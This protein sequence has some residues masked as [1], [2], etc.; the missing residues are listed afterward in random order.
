MRNVRFPPEGSAS[1][2]AR[3][4]IKE[5][6]PSMSSLPLIARSGGPLAGIVR[7]PGDRALTLQALALGA[8]AVGRTSLRGAF[9]GDEAQRLAA[10]LRALGAGV[11]DHGDGHWTVDGI[12]V[13]GLLEP[14]DVLDLGGGQEALYLLLGLVATHSLTAIFTGDAALNRRPVARLTMSLERIGAQFIGRRGDLPPLAAV[15]A[16]APMPMEHRLPATGASI[17]AA[18]LL[19][20]L[21]T[22]GITSVVESGPAS[23]AMERLLR[24]FGARVEVE[25]EAGGIRRTRLEGQPELTPAA[26]DLPADPSAA[27]LP[28]V[29]ALAAG[30]SSVTLAGVG[31]DPART[32]LF[33][34]LRDMGADIDVVNARTLGEAPVGDL[35]VRSSRLKGLVVPPERMAGLVHDYPLLAVAAARAE[36]TT[37]LSGLGDGR[38]H[39][40]LADGLAACGVEVL[41]EDD[42]LTI[43]GAGGPVPGGA[44]LAADLAPDLAAALLVLGLGAQAPVEVADGRAI[45]GHFPGFAALM[46]GLGAILTSETV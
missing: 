7:V 1:A 31:L 12:G 37:V 24:L 16:T 21:N 32:G 23:D 17:K 19:A 41:V 3:P 43:R 35:H 46:G 20:G 8:M 5:T 2:P 44:R 10:A 33:A 18:I 9:D 34:I 25:I 14:A 29:A 38:R 27:A 22:P 45:D 39:A 42:V 30:G 40:V 26:V 36:G 4:A 11:A 6:R 28:L 13:G 15:G